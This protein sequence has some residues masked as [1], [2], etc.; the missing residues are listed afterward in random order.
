MARRRSAAQAVHAA[1][2]LCRLG[3]G[4]LANPHWDWRERG[5][6]GTTLGQP[7]WIWQ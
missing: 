7:G 2:L 6:W 5:K 4:Q 3:C 1:P